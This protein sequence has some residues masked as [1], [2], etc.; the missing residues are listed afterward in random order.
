LLGT[1][2]E[3]HLA[4]DVPLGS[5]LSGGIDS[6]LVTAVM[7][8]RRP[9]PIK[10][11]CIGFDDPAHNE[12]QHA[13][14]VA[15]HL[16]TEHH[17]MPVTGQDALDLVP[18]LAGMFDEPYADVSALPAALVCKLA[19]RDVTVALS[20]EGG[21]EIFGGYNRYTYANET[22]SRLD[23]IPRPLRPALGRM[24]AVP[25]P[26][27]WDRMA[28]ILAP[29]LPRHARHRLA[30]E[31]VGK[32]VAL[33]AHDGTAKR[34]RSLVSAWPDPAALLLNGDVTSWDPIEDALAR[35]ERTDPL[36]QLLLADQLT[37][38][39]GDQLARADRVSMASSLELRVPLL[40][41]RIVE[42]SWRL[43]MAMKIQPGRGKS[44][45]RKTLYRFVPAELVE[46][47]KVG[48]SVPLAR[49]LGGPLRDWAGS[50]LARDAVA[51]ANLLNPEPVQQA[52]KR[53]CEGRTELAQGLW[54]I[55][56]LRAWEDHEWARIAA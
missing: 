27:V 9:D 51:R 25:R 28:A 50:L 35:T 3:Q 40:D 19:R 21:D 49:W 1:V 33:L 47:P 45:L 29:V 5:F 34:Y 54:A 48:F 41:H 17:Q 26:A 38:L 56:M 14:D 8:S 11:Y 23:R 18:A 2:V 42:F 15:R 53:F 6:S 43:P 46:R 4:S 13:A 55:L 12:A 44:I 52:W 20:G 36:S 32:V 37:Y 30:G 31:K 10:T 22:F 7:Q 24:L 39:P 16:G